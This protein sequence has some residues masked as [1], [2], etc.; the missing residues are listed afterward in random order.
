MWVNENAQNTGRSYFRTS[1]WPT[2]YDLAIWLETA[3]RSDFTK[4]TTKHGHGLSVARGDCSLVLCPSP[5]K[6]ILRQV[7]DIK[8]WAIR[9]F[10]ELWMWGP[11]SWCQIAKFWFWHRLDIMLP[12][13][14]S[15]LNRYRNNLR[16][17]GFSQSKA[18]PLIRR[19][20]STVLYMANST[21]P[22]I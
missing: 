9:V 2:D 16:W 11:P 15:L 14:G 10:I 19:V 8:S 3:R 20:Q 1:T 6:F 12:S 18:M 22:L 17:T 21:N 5:Q 7:V 13:S 4:K